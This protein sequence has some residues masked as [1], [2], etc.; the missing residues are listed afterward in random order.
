MAQTGVLEAREPDVPHDV[1]DR[2]RRLA[3][4]QSELEHYR[5]GGL[6]RMGRQRM[7]SR[8]ARYHDT[9]LD[10]ADS[11][12]LRWLSRDV[13]ALSA[14]IDGNRARLEA[15][16]DHTAAVNDLVAEVTLL[17]SDATRALIS[18]AAIPTS[19]S[20]FRSSVAASPV[21]GSSVH[22]RHE[23]LTG[24]PRD[25]A[26]DGETSAG[27][28]SEHR[29]QARQRLARLGLAR[30]AGS[31]RQAAGPMSMFRRLRD[32]PVPPLELGGIPR[33]ELSAAL[34][35]YQLSACIPEAEC[36]ICLSQLRK[37]QSAVNLDCG[38][39]F[40]EACI[41]EACAHRASCPLCRTI[42]RHRSSVESACPE[43]WAVTTPRITI[44]VTGDDQRD[45]H[46]A[47]PSEH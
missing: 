21:R 33:S 34:H 13:R 16:R 43:A 36:A 23:P 40:H 38:H 25:A 28:D 31:M 32:V 18:S 4:L 42:V 6:S 26:A 1:E 9:E 29:S 41:R 35:A 20:A 30:A 11:R 15:I 39:M 46:S 8:V 5:T 27:D 17:A 10:G 14:S 44:H 37:G 22:S 24:E 3:H 12:E 7:S 19:A 47:P 45:I 2:V